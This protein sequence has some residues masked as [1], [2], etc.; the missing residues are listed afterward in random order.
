MRNSSSSISRKKWKPEPTSQ[1]PSANE[2]GATIRPAG[3]KK[4]VR[5]QHRAKPAPL[6]FGYAIS[7]RER[8]LTIDPAPAISSAYCE[9]FFYFR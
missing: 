5:W 4:N 3:F 7:D 8:S 2:A 9:N 6:R 1:P